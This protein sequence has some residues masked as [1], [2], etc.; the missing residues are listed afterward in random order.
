MVIILDVVVRTG[1]LAATKLP[2]AEAPYG[3]KRKAGLAPL[4][5]DADVVFS[6]ANAFE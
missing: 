6:E 2:Q 3:G 1:R 4:R 5:A